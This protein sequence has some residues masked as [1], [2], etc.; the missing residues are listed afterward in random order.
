MT[1]QEMDAAGLADRTMGHVLDVY[2]TASEILNAW[3]PV[4]GIGQHKPL[5]DA[6]ERLVSLF[7]ERPAEITP[8]WMRSRGLPPGEYEIP[9]EAVKVR[10]GGRIEADM[11][12][13]RPVIHPLPAPRLVTV[14][15]NHA[16]YGGSSWLHLEFLCWSSLQAAEIQSDMARHV[17]KI[18]AEITHPMREVKVA[19]GDRVVGFMPALAAPYSGEPLSGDVY[20]EAAKKIWPLGGECLRESYEAG[21]AA[22][23]EAI[24]AAKYDAERDHSEWSVRDVVVPPYS[25]KGDDT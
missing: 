1:K 16:K 19:Q 15:T 17:G 10:E 13:A 25:P 22:A 24:A 6:L 14:R 8:P 7:P 5:A 2:R 12:K 18:A 9:A 4:R 11:S 23:R 3:L 20:R 21:V